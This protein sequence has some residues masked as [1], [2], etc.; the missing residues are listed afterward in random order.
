MRIC[1]EGV[2]AIRMVT[3]ELEELGYLERNRKRNEKNNLNDIEYVCH[4]R[5]IL[6]S[7]GT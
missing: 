4:K 1:I 2:D 7:A 5:A 3:R 6:L